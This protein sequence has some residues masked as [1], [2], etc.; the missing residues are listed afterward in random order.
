M[1]EREIEERGRQRKTTE[2]K[3]GAKAETAKAGK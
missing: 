2:I 1:T 3:G